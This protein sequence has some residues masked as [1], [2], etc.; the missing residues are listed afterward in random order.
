M[1]KNVTFAEPWVLYFLLIIP[2]LLIWYFIKGKKNYASVKYSS[3]NIFKNAPVTLR[4][5]LK[6]F[7]FLLRMIAL[8]LLIIAL[9]RPQSFT[10]GENFST[11]GIDIAMVLDISGSMLAEDLK[12]N[13]LEA[14]KNV[15]DDFTEG[16]VS[17]RI[18]LVIFSREAFTQC[19]L[20]IDYNVLRNLLLE[21]RSGMIEDGT[22]IGL[23]LATAVSRLKDSEAKS[24]VVILLTD[25][26]NNRGSVTPLAAADIAAAFDIRVYTIGVGTI[27]QAKGPVGRRPN[28][29]FVYDMVDV[30]IDEE[31][32]KEISAQ[33]D[34]KY[35]RATDNSKLKDIYEEIDLLE[36]T[37]IQ[38]NSYKST[39]EEYLPL[40][41]FALIL[42]LLEVLLKHTYFRSIP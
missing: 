31:T 26:V 25:G 3:V 7:P 38:E 13:R 28:G 16:R 1:L 34:G 27:G 22:A 12:P 15:I 8:G 18:G 36:K 30:T 20:T 11:E 32:L 5:R 29:T 40:A 35:F 21:I 39:K 4:E 19:P 33:T 2:L 41:L 37:K 6:Y 14:A 24:K 9:A 10:A 42:F 17:D 23:G